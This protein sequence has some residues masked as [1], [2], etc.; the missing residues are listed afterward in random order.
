VTVICI[1]YHGNC[2]HTQ[3]Y[4]APLHVTVCLFIKSD[5]QV[6]S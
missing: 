2:Q 4:R 5:V 6:T 1:F 3:E